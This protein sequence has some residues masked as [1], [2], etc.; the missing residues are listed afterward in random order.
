V[1]R[2]LGF[3]S[4]VG[5]VEAEPTKKQTQLNLGRDSLGFIQQ[6]GKQF[7]DLSS[8]EIRQPV[9]EEGELLKPRKT[10]AAMATSMRSS[11]VEK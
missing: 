3:L 2:P 1:R 6:K 5:L 4:P 8:N 10:A 9:D 7:N 11:L